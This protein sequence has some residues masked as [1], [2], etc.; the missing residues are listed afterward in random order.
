MALLAKLW[1]A[2]GRL[3]SL[4]QGKGAAGG[5]DKKIATNILGMVLLPG[6]GIPLRS[7]P[8]VVL[9]MPLVGA[10]DASLQDLAFSNAIAWVGL[11]NAQ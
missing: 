1:C 6:S 5:C 3:H 2:P 10:V 8:R 9:I 7:E 4:H 11:A